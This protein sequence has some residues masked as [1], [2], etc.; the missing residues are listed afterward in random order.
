MNKGVYFAG[1]T[2][3]LMGFLAIAIK[4]SLNAV[5]PVTVAWFRFAL[6]F[7]VLFVYYLIFDKSKLKILKKPPL[8]ALLAAV[9][10]SVN[11]VGY[12]LGIN[13]TTPS[14]AQI[15]I[16]VGPVL[17]A[18][19]GFV[20]FK[21]KVSIRQSLGLLVV[22]GGLA[23]FY[24]EQ[25]LNIAG[26]L[27][28][29]VIGVGFVVIAGI[30]WASYGIFQKLAIK[31][32]NPMQLNLIIFGLPII[33][34]SPFVSFN[35]FVGLSLNDWLLLIFLG[36]NTLGAYGSLAYALKYLEA[37]KISVILTANPLI[38]LS[39]MALLSRQ[40]VSW[41][42][43]EVFTTITIVGA[44]TVLLGVVLTVMKKRRKISKI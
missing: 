29:Y 41:I 21:E 28:E 9:G 24:N 32:H 12:I 33:I 8:F 16:Q 11:Y 31:S 13:L 26:G 38:T 34:L 37:N 3:L 19:S 27:K 14:I 42:A 35:Q 10:L 4:V 36:L 7:V 23:V 39:T 1:F 43:P 17:L 30:A 15:F 6:A 44:L 22:V 40:K 25:I 5:L 2:A 20:I 18:V